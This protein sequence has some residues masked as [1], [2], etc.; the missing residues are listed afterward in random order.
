M[1]LSVALCTFNGENFLSEQL[2]SILLQ[3]LSINEIIICDDCSVDNTIGIVES[4]RHKYPDV[5]HL[6]KNKQSLGTIKNFEKAIALTTGE[7]IFLS[8]QDDIWHKDKVEIMVNFFNENNNCKLLFTNGDLI[9]ENGA[10][11]NATLWEKWGF[12]IEMQ[13]KWKN[14]KNAF[15]DLIVNN[16]KITGATVCIHSSLKKYI[17][18]IEIPY[19]YWH[20]CWFGLQAAANGGLMFLE[21]N[22]IKY[23][24]HKNQ[25]IGTSSNVIDTITI[26]ANKQFITKEACFKKVIKMYPALRKNIPF[27][28]KSNFKKMVLKITN[29]FKS[30]N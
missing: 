27:T 14:N 4:Y 11:L 19:G 12:S 25:Q 17:L 3:S 23:R 24:V 29:Y 10:S 5:I 26:N 8:D 6:Y 22:L 2:E 1:T 9:N 21:N 16:N 7:L 28:P 18:P 20:D 30:F 13:N 15:Q